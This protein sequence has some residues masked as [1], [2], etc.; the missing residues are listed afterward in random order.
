MHLNLNIKKWTNKKIFYTLEV[1]I[2]LKLAVL[3]NIVNV[4]MQVLDVLD[5]VNV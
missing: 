3:R 2:V 1:V 4:I 5:C